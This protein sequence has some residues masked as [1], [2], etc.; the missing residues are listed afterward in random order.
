MDLDWLPPQS[1][2]H[3]PFRRNAEEESSRS[4]RKSDSRSIATSARFLLIVPER[5]AVQAIFLEKCYIDLNCIF[6]SKKSS[7]ERI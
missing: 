7:V 4:V 2:T 1:H 6:A 3:L 5:D